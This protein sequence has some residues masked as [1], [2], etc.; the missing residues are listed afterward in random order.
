MTTWETLLH[1]VFMDEES[2][3][4]VSVN[5][6]INREERLSKWVI[7]CNIPRT[8]VIK[9]LIVLKK[10]RRL[11]FLPMYYRTSQKTFRKVVPIS[12]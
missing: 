2:N 3:Q 9:L 8:H 11:D 10:Y 5:D 6:D 12:I 4:S 7:V 1:C